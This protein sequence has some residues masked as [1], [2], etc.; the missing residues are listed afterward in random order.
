MRSAL[1]NSKIFI[2]YQLALYG[3]KLGL[4]IYNNCNSGR[5]LI[6]DQNLSDDQLA[7]VS[8]SSTVIDIRSSNGY[9]DGFPINDI[10][11]LIE[12]IATHRLVYNCIFL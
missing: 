2:G 4:D 7:M 11:F 3:C 5:K 9:I 10:D 1:Y 8:N 12:G 6:N